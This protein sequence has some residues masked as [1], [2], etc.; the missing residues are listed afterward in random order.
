[1]IY[2]GVD[3]GDTT[4]LFAVNLYTLDTEAAEIT[5]PQDTLRWVHRHIM[6]VQAEVAIERFYIGP[7]TVRSTRH[8][9]VHDVIGSIK[10]LCESIEIPCTLQDAASAKSFASNARLKSINWYTRARPHAN[11]AARHALLL[12]ARRNPDNFLSLIGE[13]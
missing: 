11:D 12:V 1:M 13:R 10:S 3:P 8:P 4:G 7:R 5:D 6:G 9:Q 2:V